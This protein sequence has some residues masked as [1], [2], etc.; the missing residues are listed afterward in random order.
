[1][2]MQIG[3]QDVKKTNLP[4]QANR[5]HRGQYGNDNRHG[6]LNRP[7]CYPEPVGDI[8]RN[9]KVHRRA[10]NAEQRD[11]HRQDE[12][13]GRLAHAEFLRFFEHQRQTGER[14]L[15]ADRQRLHRGNGPRKPAKRDAPLHH[16]N[17]IGDQPDDDSDG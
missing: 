9:R 8:K 6:P 12:A 17:G 13:C 11:R 5:A 14:R 16:R 1:M 7:Q 15:G 10:S 3:A 2:A 4:G